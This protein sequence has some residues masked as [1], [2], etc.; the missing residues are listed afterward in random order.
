M[1]EMCRNMSAKDPNKRKLRKVF[2]KKRNAFIM[3][4][5]P[6]GNTQ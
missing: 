5:R 4:A 1:S 3:F 2:I 6:Q